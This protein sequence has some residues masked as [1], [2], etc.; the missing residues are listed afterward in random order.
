MDNCNK[1]PLLF[2]QQVKDIGCRP[3]D[4]VKP[5]EYDICIRCEGQI[6]ILPGPDIDNFRVLLA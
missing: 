4:G 3:D 1:R 2:F 6:T 5:S